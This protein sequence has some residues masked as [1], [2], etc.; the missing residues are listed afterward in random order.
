MRSILVAASLVVVALSSAG[1]RS[2]SAKIQGVETPTPGATEL[3]VRVS[4]NRL[5]KVQDE[6]RVVAEFAGHVGTAPLVL[7]PEGS[8][9]ELVAPVIR[10]WAPGEPSSADRVLV[11]VMFRNKQLARA[12]FPPPWDPALF[13]GR[14][15]AAP[16]QPTSS[17]TDLL[18]PNGEPVKRQPA[19]G[20]SASTDLRTPDAGGHDGRTGST[21]S[22]NPLAPN[23]TLSPCPTCAEPRGSQTPC[24]HCGIR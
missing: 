7:T 16:R 8:Q 3:L 24:P 17:R 22:T 4:A 21:T 18:A 19:G 15:A 14:A 10:S 1:C 2:G 20:S 13:G 6:C 5:W 9:P 11:K 12:Q 23:A